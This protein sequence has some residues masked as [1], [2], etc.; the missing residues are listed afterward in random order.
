MSASKLPP[1]SQALPNCDYCNQVETSG[2]ILRGK[3]C[4]DNCFD[5]AYDKKIIHIDYT[6]YRGERATRRVRVNHIGFGHNEYHVKEQWLLKAWC[7]ERSAMR[8]FAIDDI[9]NYNLEDLT[10]LFK[11]Q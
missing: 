9:H 11:E 8:D 5:E 6:N 7:Y 2:A 10:K 3:P 4:C 1:T